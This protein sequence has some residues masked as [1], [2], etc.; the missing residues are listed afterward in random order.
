MS[1]YCTHM[2][3]GLFHAMPIIFF[4]FKIFCFYIQVSLNMCK[5]I[6]QND[7]IIRSACAAAGQDKRFSSAREKSKFHFSI[8]HL[9]KLGRL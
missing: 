7:I 8:L 4:S 5:D 2:S 6:H 9:D 1:L 3:Y